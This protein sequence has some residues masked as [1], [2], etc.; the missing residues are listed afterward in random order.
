MRLIIVFI[1]SFLWCCT[2]F[3]EALTD[4]VTPSPI[5]NRVG[6]V[7]NRRHLRRQQ[8]NEE[9]RMAPNFAAMSNL[10]H[11]TPSGQSSQILHAVENHEPLPKW[12]KAL[13]VLLG[14]G[15][16]AGGTVAAVKVSQSITE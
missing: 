15:V 10:L 2:S 1:A 7:N 9:E 16:V 13:V 8:P 3:T 5:T 4:N 6:N 12:A 14:L 11:S